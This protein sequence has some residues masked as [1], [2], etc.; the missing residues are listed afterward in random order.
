MKASDLTGQRFGHL[1]ALSRV[2]RQ[3]EGRQRTYWACRCD[4]GAT[5][6]VRL[7][8]LIQGTTTS[9]GCLRREK[10]NRLKHGH[11]V[12][13]STSGTYETWL[14]M[15]RRCSDP[16]HDGAKNYL[17][18]GIKVCERW[19]RFEDFLADMGERPAGKTIDR[20]DNDG[21]YEPGNCRWA[22]KREQALNTRRSKGSH[23]ERA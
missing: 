11:A 17:G 2:S 1:V 18:R 10:H 12:N 14:S 15:V 8:N 3:M 22:T 23:H 20:I 13:G 6:D 7:S 16:S 9:C 21:N 5:L 4:C 19:A